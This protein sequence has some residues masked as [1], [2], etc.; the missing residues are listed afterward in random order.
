MHFAKYYIKIFGNIWTVDWKEIIS[1]QTTFFPL[2]DL[3]R[4]T[5]SLKSLTWTR[6]LLSPTPITAYVEDDF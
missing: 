3:Y 2:L 5:L 1:P 4:P 6:R